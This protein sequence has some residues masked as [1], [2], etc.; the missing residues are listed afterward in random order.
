MANAWEHSRATPAPP[1]PAHGVGCGTARQGL[2]IPQGAAPSSLLPLALL[3]AHA[4]LSP[5]TSTTALC[6]FIGISGAQHCR[7]DSSCASH[8]VARMDGG[9]C[10]AQ[11]LATSWAFCPP[12]LL[13]LTHPVALAHAPLH[14]H[15]D[16]IC[17]R[18]VQCVQDTLL[19]GG[20]EPVRSAH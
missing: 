5:A 12:L 7:F 13:P 20:Q 8:C 3:C 11:Q 15:I 14:C 10:A 9:S 16:L 18:A 6:V 1:G 17:S 2:S 4:K 19:F